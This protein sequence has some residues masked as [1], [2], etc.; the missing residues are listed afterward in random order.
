M[1]TRR[2]RTRKGFTLLELLLV[3]AILIVLAGLAGFSVLGMQ[4][5]AY[6]NAAQLQIENFESMCKAYRLNT[7]SFPQKLDDLHVLPS[8]MNRSLWG[9]PYLEE[10]VPLD[11]WQMKYEYVIDTQNDRVVIR[12]NGPDKQKG[13]PDDIPVVQ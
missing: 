7:G 6:S 5:R 2:P 8:G 3:M 11:P 9:G 1:R 13:T 4:K 10:P 12:S